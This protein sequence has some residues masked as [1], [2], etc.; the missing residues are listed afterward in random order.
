MTALRSVLIILIF[1]FTPCIPSLSQTNPIK[2]YRM[3]DG[4]P[5]N[6]IKRI[7]QDSIGFIWVGTELGITRFDGYTFETFVSRG[8]LPSE[9]VREM[10]LDSTNKGLWVVLDDQIIH[11]SQDGKIE[12]LCRMQD[13]NILSI[14]GANALEIDPD[15]RLWIGTPEGIFS[16]HPTEGW[17]EISGRTGFL[18]HNASCLAY[19]RERNEIWVTIN[20]R[21]IFRYNILHNTATSWDLFENIPSANSTD[22]ILS[23]ISNPSAG[24]IWITSTAGVHRVHGENCRT[25]SN[26][27]HDVGGHTYFKLT[28]D[29]EGNLWHVLR[30]NDSRG[31]FYQKLSHRDMKPVQRIFNTDF[32]DILPSGTVI[33]DRNGSIWIG[34]TGLGLVRNPQILEYSLSWSGPSPPRNALAYDA[35]TMLISTWSGIFRLTSDPTVAPEYLSAKV[36][37]NLKAASEVMR[38]PDHSICWTQLDFGHVRYRNGEMQHLRQP[39]NFY[40]SKLPHPQQTQQLPDGSILFIVPWKSDTVYV[41]GKNGIRKFSSHLPIEESI[42]ERAFLVGRRYMGR[43]GDL[44]IISSKRIYRLRHERIERS[45]GRNE[46]YSS[47]LFQSCICEDSTGS[48]WIANHRRPDSIA[49]FRLRNDSLTTFTQ[50]E[51]GLPLSSINAL[52]VSPDGRL[53]LISTFNGL[54]FLDLQT[55]RIMHSL[56]AMTG[57]W[58]SNTIGALF[59]P[60]SV[61]WVLTGNGVTR[62]PLVRK[63]S[64]SPPLK[65]FITA[66]VTDDSERVSTLRSTEHAYASIP[67]RIKFIFTTFSFQSSVRYL[68]R[69]DGYDEDWSIPSTENSRQYTNLSPGTYRFRVK[70]VDDFLDRRSIECSY[71]IT[72]PAPFYQTWWFAFLLC[73]M[74]SSVVYIGHRIRVRGRKRL[75]QIRRKIAID[76]HDEVGSTLAS[77]SML[78]AVVE[79]ALP[80][81]QM[82]VAK[83]IAQIGTTSRSVV[84]LLRDIVWSL[85]PEYD[86]MSDLYQKLSDMIE[87]QSD[88]HNIE[89]LLTFP[90]E[91]QGRMLRQ[92]LR[93]NLY[94]IAREAIHNAIKHS[95]CSTIN[96]HF[97]EKQ[98]KLVMS[99]ADNGISFDFARQ[100]AGTGM[101]SMRERA[102][103]IRAEYSITSTIGR[104]TCVTI[105]VPTIKKSMIMRLKRKNE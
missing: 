73:V 88:M 5:T 47:T 19:Y 80:R 60:D 23:M 94:L 38:G 45:F 35:Q 18:I 43:S 1:F 59:W 21:Q 67:S 51:L 24:G 33:E 30:T 102:K 68:T 2:W 50:S 40:S 42:D 26:L 62:I 71:T 3:S 54:Y 82:D 76:L 12:Q 29:K 85:H 28:L 69:L 101:K 97:S 20:R 98:K 34:T 36:G 100:K 15:R 83:K 52:T 31:Y 37:K 72:I 90:M 57:Y 58:Q 78:S 6:L 86:S 84:G 79:K 17:R 65:T 4:L 13:G 10:C 55:L 66:I 46:G 64:E 14:P 92:D 77:V 96:V 81:D 103:E 8:K 91:L 105:I 22:Y 9:L 61:L 95:R 49:L 41:F 99:I 7:V 70:A 25:M 63:Q 27:Y 56:T 93:R 39:W 11:V 32:K 87:E 53:M 48:V 104:G 16:V 75:E 89:I 44:F 74:L